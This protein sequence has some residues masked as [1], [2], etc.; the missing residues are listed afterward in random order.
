MNQVG[1]AAR[2]AGVA[3]VL[4]AAH[5]HAGIEPPT[6]H[7][8]DTGRSP[9]LAGWLV[10][11]ST[12]DVDF[13]TTLVDDAGPGFSRPTRGTVTSSVIRAADGS[14][15][16]YW[17]ISNASGGVSR[18]DVA[19]RSYASLALKPGWRLDGPGG[20][21]PQRAE[22]DGSHVSFGFT[23]RGEYGDTGG[24][25]GGRS[26]A[27][28]SASFFLDTNTHAFDRS[29]SFMLTSALDTQGA[30]GA[31]VGNSPRFSTFSPSPGGI[32]PVPEPETWGTMLSGLGLMGLWFA[33]RRPTE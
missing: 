2:L 6:L 1:N 25:L 30:G 12:Q 20:R 19:L 23:D 14:Y 32:A 15:D 17:R 22:R 24:A 27:S 18:F 21:A 9:W 28:D 10:A 16:F 8:T 7:G 4:A 13:T 26:A 31:I 3:L 33:K 5:A 29:G 11:T